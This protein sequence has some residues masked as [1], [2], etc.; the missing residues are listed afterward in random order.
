MDA[1]QAI[2]GSLF[3]GSSGGGGGGGG[4]GGWGDASEP[5]PTFQAPPQQIPGSSGFGGQSVDFNPPANTG[6]VQGASTAATAPDPYAQWGGQAA[7]NNLQSGFDTQKQ[8]I[9]GSSRDAANNAAIGR[10]S[11]ILDF[12]QG[13]RSGQRGLDERGVQ[14]E[15]A[16]KQG[17][18][19][20]LDMVGR[21]I[22]SGG[23]MLANKNAS[24][25][26]ATEALARAYGQIGQRQ[27]GNIG[28]QY[29]LENRNI[30]LAQDEF[31]TNRQTGL[32]K[33]DENKTQ[34]VNSI[35]ADARNRLAALDAAMAEASMPERIQIENEKESIKQEAINILS[36]Y[37]QQLTNDAAAVQ[38]TGTED[39]RRTAAGL[40][41]AG[42]AAANPFDFTA[43]VP[44]QF[45]G[46]G[47]FSS[48]LP[49]FTFPRRQEA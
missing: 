30:G 12:V 4:G 16:K 18:G 22:R 25:S 3:G 31:N 28:N 17:T 21:G 14:N 20:I 2:F 43:S 27:L 19:S 9:Y 42:M 15:L 45:Q 7:Y 34:T 13:L 32:R 24:N 41:S 29:E 1:I 46:T 38:P 11:S 36:Q 35:V 10:Q 33:F 37:D 47:P 26:S 44:A 5:L 40:A 49:I 39:R 8:N 23:V 48:E 6:Q